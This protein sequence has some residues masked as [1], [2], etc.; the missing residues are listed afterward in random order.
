M[1][2]AHA[3]VIALLR[4]I[5]EPYNLAQLSIEAVLRALQPAALSATRERI[6]LIQSERAQLVAALQH[7][8]A[9]IRVWPSAA[10]FLLVEFANPQ[11]AFERACAAGLLV[12]DVRRQPGLDRSLRLTVGTPQQN[13][14]LIAALKVCK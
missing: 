5:V 4:R 10:N 2:L 12:R 13:Q 8:D 6:A 14:R 9:V 1:V 3:D 7:C 11:W